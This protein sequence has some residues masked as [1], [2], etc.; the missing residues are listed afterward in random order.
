MKTKLKEKLYYA[1]EISKK[2]IE[3]GSTNKKENNKTLLYEEPHQ[4]RGFGQILY[5]E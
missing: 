5:S 1:D 3:Y 4:G 2:C